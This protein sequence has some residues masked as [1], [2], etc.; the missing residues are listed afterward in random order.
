MHGKMKTWQFVIS[1]HFI[2]AF[3]C[4]A[5]LFA[6]PAYADNPEAKNADPAKS[7]AQAK[8]VIEKA[9]AAAT[10]GNITEADLLFQKAIT[11]APKWEIAYQAQGAFYTSIKNYP[12][13]AISWQKA[14][15]LSPGNK[16][17]REQLAESLF[18]STDWDAAEV[19]WTEIAEEQLDNI[20]AKC[21]LA[22]IA[23]RKGEYE[24]ADKIINEA[25]ELSPTNVQVLI[26]Y[27]QLDLRFKRY[28]KARTRIESVLATLPESDP[29]Y[30]SAESI[31]KEAQ[32]GC[33]RQN[34][35]VA[36]F[37]LAPFIVGG[38]VYYLYKR[39]S[40]V[41][42]K[43]APLEL[44]A[45][46]EDSACRFV[47]MH[48]INITQLPRG[49]CWTTTLDGRRLELQLS[50]LISDQK[51][52]A[53]CSMDRNALR[54]WLEGH[55]KA[56]F[57]FKA[58]AKE[59]LFNKAF[60]T[61]VQDLEGVEIN[62]GI[63]IVWKNELLGL[64]LLGRSR[65]SKVSALR[66]RFEENAARLQ[67]IA[68]QTAVALDRLRQKKLKVLDSKTG[69]YNRDYFENSLVNIYKG[70]HTAGVPLSIFM[71]KMD[72]FSRLMEEKDEDYWS[73]VLYTLAQTIISALSTEVNL[74]LCHLDAGVFALIAPERNASEAEELARLLK[75]KIDA[76]VLPDKTV[77]CTSCIA[78]AVYPEDADEP[79][80]LRAV[81]T[82]AFRD[83]NYLQGNRIVRAEQANQGGKEEKAAAPPEEIVVSRRANRETSVSSIGRAYTPFMPGAALAGAGGSQPTVSA[84]LDVPS[85]I[86]APKSAL[87]SSP[88]ARRTM[89]AGSPF[90]PKPED[91]PETEE[92]F[93]DNFVIEPEFDEDGFDK[94]TQFCSQ[95]SFEEL[96]DYEMEESESPCAVVYIKLNN[97]KALRSKGKEAYM[98]LRR[99]LSA[100]IGAFL[101]DDIDVPG[102]YG[103][104]DFAVFLTGSE[105]SVASNLA[106]RINLTARNLD[107]G[108]VKVDPSI[109]VAVR[110]NEK[111][112]GTTL[113]ERA[114][115]AA[116]GS[117]IKIHGK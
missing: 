73:D 7:Q 35:V 9:V 44:D 4:V 12:N 53:V 49:L 68:E 93:D 85:S 89:A 27:S 75:K 20:N 13:A 83:A 1:K 97:L 92:V 79:K 42:F 94:E 46:T 47:L 43:S 37:C 91:K 88:V 86:P 18:E 67:D 11:L 60:P 29:L 45:T 57:L 104:D 31:L 28:K 48:S 8:K 54:E 96:V 58:E 26:V 116:S 76:T 39:Q 25:F 65:S 71:M 110:H 106:D 63:P 40:K 100:L 117:G 77:H 38:V 74:T 81:V 95:E 62:V 103:S 107:A 16:M 52:V 3:I 34:Y 61:L 66:Q 101:R 112:D 105:L 59:E 21:K 10:A 6:V 19:I 41:A 90:A 102:L 24:K 108:G 113:I 33:R 114:Q 23:M 98:Q 69:L 78:Y 99:D 115:K 72:Q 80:I 30:S 70:C 32:D 87:E 15:E 82:R 51:E 5:F 111:L 109:G 56:P 14:L 36:G 84:R 22:I 64:T 55:G 2:L 17:Y 50:E